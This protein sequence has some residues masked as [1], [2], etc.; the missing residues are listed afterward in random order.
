MESP[1]RLVP[2]QS[3]RLATATAT[4]LRCESEHTAGE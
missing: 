3:D 4:A 1:A 2:S